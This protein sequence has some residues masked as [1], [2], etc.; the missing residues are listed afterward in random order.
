M[1]SLALPTD[2]GLH[3]VL[4]D[5]WQQVKRK[6]WYRG[7]SQA[8]ALFAAIYEMSLRPSFHGVGE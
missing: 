8:G 3:P 7:H 6:F 5:L 4:A 1:L 2:P